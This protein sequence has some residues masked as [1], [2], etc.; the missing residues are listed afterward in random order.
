V[1]HTILV[2]DATHF[3]FIPHAEGN[4]LTGTPSP[5]LVSLLACR[6]ALALDVRYSRL[7]GGLQRHFMHPSTA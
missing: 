4:G 7:D 5:E 1:G 2:D 3:D 6:A